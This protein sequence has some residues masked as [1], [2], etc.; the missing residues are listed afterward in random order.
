MVGGQHAGKVSNAPPVKHTTVDSSS[1]SS[2]SSS[3][4]NSSSCSPM[5]LHKVEGAGE[6]AVHNSLSGVDAICTDHL[7]GMDICYPVIASWPARYTQCMLL[8]SVAMSLLV[9]TSDCHKA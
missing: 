3:S 2:S 1:S 9:H 7:G 8:Q 6:G 4:N 5:C